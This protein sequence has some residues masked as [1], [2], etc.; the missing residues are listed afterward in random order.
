MEMIWESRKRWC[1]SLPPETSSRPALCASQSWHASLA[2]EAFECTLWIA[3]H[4][5]KVG[6]RLLGDSIFFLESIR[7]MQLVVYRK[8][9]EL[10]SLCHVSRR[11]GAQLKGFCGAEP[12]CGENVSRFGGFWAMPVPVPGAGFS[13]AA[14]TPASA[15]DY[16]READPDV[17]PQTT[18]AHSLEGR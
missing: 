9:T 17:R 14:A 13:A 4:A 3:R 18:W 2:A 6:W 15:R 11:T 16:R 1:G 7:C 10:Q 8:R 5:T 12:V